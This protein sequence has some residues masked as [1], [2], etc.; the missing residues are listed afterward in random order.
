MGPVILSAAVITVYAVVHG[1]LPASIAFTTISILGQIEGTLA[2]IPELTTQMLDAYVSLKRITEYLASSEK[3][4]FATPGAQIMFQ[5]AS[6]T[7]PSDENKDGSIDV[8]RFALRDVNIA[9]P[10][11]ELSVISGRTGS[12]KSLLLAAILGEVDLLSGKIEIPPAPPM[13]ERHDEKANKSN[14]I[15]PNAIA[16]VSQQPWIENASFK[17]NILFGLPFDEQRYKKVLSACSLDKDLE[18]M[19]DGDRQEIGAQGINLSGG[20]KWRI[21]L[22]RALYSRAGILVMDDIF[23]AVDAHVG[24][25]IFEEALT[26][27]ICKG[28]T[29]ILVTHHVSLVLS[30]TKYEVH[31]EN[32]TVKHAGLVDELKKTGDLDEVLEDE[33]EDDVVDET[34]SPQLS[35]QLSRRKSST[36]RL[37]KS[38]GSILS[39][40]RSSQTSVRSAM[41]DDGTGT[42]ANAK[43]AP[44]KFIEDEKVETGKVKYRI[45]KQYLQAGGGLFFW[46]TVAIAF[47]TYQALLL[48]RSWILK[49]WT[50]NYDEKSINTWYSHND[51][52][53]VQYVGSPVAP[54]QMSTKMADGNQDLK[55]YLGL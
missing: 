46:F 28:R 32:G 54:A 7:F 22:G 5:D 38:N 10:N 51:V 9:F 2:Y 42:A 39:K 11:G 19:P 21:T 37:S 33:E 55:F 34:L 13:A 30:A 27:E 44:K 26:G 12:G 49:S 53:R 41:V 23:S 15:V 20:Q 14:W 4:Q 18:I 24:K 29:R 36:R 8:E 40:R 52:F 35:R 25:H 1:G 43:D 6:L 16:F 47:A 48:G 45:Y 17:D 50:Q 3:K 31:L